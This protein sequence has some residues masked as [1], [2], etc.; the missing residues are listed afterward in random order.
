METDVLVHES[1]SAENLAAP[2]PNSVLLLLHHFVLVP[3]NGLDIIFIILFRKPIE[4][5][6]LSVLW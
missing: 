6:L 3:Y 4:I 1:G 5:S 2:T